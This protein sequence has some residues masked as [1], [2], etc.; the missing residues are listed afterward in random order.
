MIEGL[1]IN[2]M[3]RIAFQRIR[4]IFE[5]GEEKDLTQGTALGHFIL[6]MERRLRHIE[7]HMLAARLVELQLEIKLEG[8]K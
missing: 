8:R 6:D 5:E 1:V 2:K 4:N 7:S 3:I